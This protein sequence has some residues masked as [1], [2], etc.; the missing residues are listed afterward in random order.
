MVADLLGVSVRHMHMLFEMTERS[1]SQTVTEERLKKARRLLVE[2]PERL[3]ADV[4]LA[5]GFES[6]ATFYR[7]FNAACGMAP[8]DYRTRGTAAV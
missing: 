5:S 4:A 3:V 8:G 7:A 1:F 2:A 6:L